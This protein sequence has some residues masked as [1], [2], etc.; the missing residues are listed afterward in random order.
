ME[1]IHSDIQSNLE[2]VWQPS[3]HGE[4]VMLRP[5]KESDFETLHNAA[6]DPLIMGTTSGL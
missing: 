1:H 4:Y 6:S 5:L 2:N 3:L